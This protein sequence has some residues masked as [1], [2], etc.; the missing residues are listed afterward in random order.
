MQST[1]DASGQGWDAAREALSGRWRLATLGVEDVISDAWERWQQDKE[2]TGGLVTG[3]GCDL[4]V[5]FIPYQIHGASAVAWNQCLK[6]WH[7]WKTCE[8]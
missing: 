1:K 3:V 5:P 4:A 8:P 7:A 6:Y 2:R